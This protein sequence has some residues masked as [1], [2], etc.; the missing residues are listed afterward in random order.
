M[1]DILLYYI[2]SERAWQAEECGK[3]EGLRRGNYAKIRQDQSFASRAEDQGDDHSENDRRRQ[4]GRGGRDTARKDPDPARIVNGLSDAPS[5]KRTETG[6]RDGRARPGQ[7]DQRL[8]NA[9]PAEDY[10]RD[11]IRY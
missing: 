9:D 4:S 8:I 6:Q 5:Q 3:K 2:I 1:I 7:L 10:S 11:H